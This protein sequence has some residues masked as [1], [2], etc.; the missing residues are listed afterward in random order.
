[1]IGGGNQE[2]ARVRIKLAELLQFLFEERGVLVSIARI[3][4]QN[5][6]VAGDAKLRQQH[7]GAFSFGIGF[8]EN[9]GITAGEG[10]FGVWKSLGQDGAFEKTLARLVQGRHTARASHQPVVGATKDND[11]GGRR[12]SVE[13]GPREAVLQRQDQHIA[14]WRQADHQ[15]KNCPEADKATA[16]S[17][18][19]GPNENGAIADQQRDQGRR[20]QHKPNGLG[21]KE[22]HRSSLAPLD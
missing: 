5:E 9:A 14:E 13:I 8:V 3:R 4:F 22:K 18:P 21:D 12:R 17:C 2:P 11:P 6:P 15:E 10:D 7:R 1:M 20:L 19:T 16:P